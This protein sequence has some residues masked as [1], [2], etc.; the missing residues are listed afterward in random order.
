MHSAIHAINRT[1]KPI[2]F[3]YLMATAKL[4]QKFEKILVCT[5]LTNKKYRIGKMILP[6]DNTEWI[7]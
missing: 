6:N 7:D 1:V 3:A 5:Q 2:Y 4:I